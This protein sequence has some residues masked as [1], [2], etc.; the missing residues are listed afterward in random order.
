MVDDEELSVAVGELELAL[1]QLGQPQGGISNQ[2]V[3]RVRL[4]PFRELV[5][6]QQVSQRI[7]DLLL[8]FGGGVLGRQRGRL[9]PAFG[10]S[11]AF[12]PSLTQGSRGGDRCGAGDLVGWKLDVEGV[13]LDSSSAMISPSRPFV[14]E[15][16][17]TVR[18]AAPNESWNER[19]HRPVRRG[20]AVLRIP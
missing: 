16:V 5:A 19:R 20:Q 17:P 9:F 3:K 2:R 4:W 15:S 13:E 11:R 6:T 8:G 12:G 10:N 1:C 14:G 7:R 18:G